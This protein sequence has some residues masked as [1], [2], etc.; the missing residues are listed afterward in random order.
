MPTRFAK[1]LVAA[2]SAMLTVAACS[3]GKPG[4]HA[5]G[6]TAAPSTKATS[7]AA[8]SDLP[9]LKTA[10][11]CARATL[12]LRPGAHP[13]SCAYST[14]HSIYLYEFDNAQAKAAEVAA[15]KSARQW[16]LVEGATWLVLTV[17]PRVVDVAVAHG[18]TLVGS[19]P[20][21]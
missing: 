1:Q 21:S 18:G 9:A 6:S 12:V 17:E 5:G 10:L 14:Q 7:T 19:L 2:F 15:L 3:S 13:F 11:K 4:T 8:S 20:T 16:G